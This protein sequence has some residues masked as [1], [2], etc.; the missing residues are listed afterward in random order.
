MGLEDD[1]GR[2]MEIRHLRVIYGSP[3]PYFLLF[4]LRSSLAPERSEL[5]ITS[6][7]PSPRNG[8][9]RKPWTMNLSVGCT[10]N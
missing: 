6:P 3:I 1:N 4:A 10:C 5:G 8:P 9:G 2:R 7:R